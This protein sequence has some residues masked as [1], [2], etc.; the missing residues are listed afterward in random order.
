MFAY[1]KVCDSSVFHPPKLF[2][3]RSIVFASYLHV[4]RFCVGRETQSTSD[5]DH[6]LHLKFFG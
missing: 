6:D 5:V 3:F 4:A 1:S 2:Y